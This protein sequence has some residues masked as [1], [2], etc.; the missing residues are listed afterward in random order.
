MGGWRVGGWAPSGQPR[1]LRC[2]PPPP[3]HVQGGTP[4]SAA[5]CQGL[6]TCWRAD[7]KALDD[8]VALVYTKTI[9][10]CLFPTH[11]HNPVRS[12]LVSFTRDA[13]N[14]TL[15]DALV[16]VIIQCALKTAVCSFLP[17]ALLFSPLSPP[18]RPLLSV[19]RF[20]FSLCPLPASSHS[21]AELALSA[22]APP[23]LPPCPTPK[24]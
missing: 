2:R 14:A 12:A 8:A 6:S 10:E 15:P 1:R 23:P 3:H 22:P 21:S 5:A 7:G 13:G 11:T 4:S 20:A 18:P 24:Y 17:P 9:L 19:S 16:C